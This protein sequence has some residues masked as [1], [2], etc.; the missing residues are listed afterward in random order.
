MERRERLDMIRRLVPALVEGENWDEIYIALSTFGI[1]IDHPANYQGSIQEYISGALLNAEDD[2]I[3]GLDDYYFSSPVTSG[4]TVPDLDT[5]SPWTEHYFRL[6]VSHVYERREDAMALKN[7]LVYFGVDAF[8]AHSDIDPSA[9]WLAVIEHALGTCDAFLALLTDGFQESRWCDQEVGYAFAHSKVIVPARFDQRVPHGFLNRKQALNLLT[10]AKPHDNALA[11][12]E[13]ILKSRE[14]T[15][16]RLVD[17]MVHRVITSHGWIMTNEVLGLIRAN[18][19]HVTSAHVALLEEA[20]RTNVEV[21]NA[22]DADYTIRL[23]RA[24]VNA[25]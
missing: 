14:V 25:R 16:A 11:V 15:V 13:T 12:V 21:S 5:P 24:T 3:Q 17:A 1:G 22:F 20:Q 18:A 10:D 23:L 9:E 8:V 4:L 6:F 19:G 2:E 7:G